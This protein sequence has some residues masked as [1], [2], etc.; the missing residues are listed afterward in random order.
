MNREISAPASAAFGVALAGLAAGP[1]EAAVVSLT[2]TPATLPYGAGTF[3]VADAYV[4][5]LAGTSAI[6]TF[7]A[8]NN[9]YGKSF[10]GTSGFFPAVSGSL[11]WIGTAPATITTGLTF[12]TGVFAT[13][14]S[15]GTRTVAFRTDANQLG[16]LRVSFG[17]QGGT[18][19][20]LAAAYETTPGA[21]IGAGEGPTAIPLPATLPLAGLGL[22]ALG[23]A[24]LRRKRTA[25]AAG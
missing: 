23:A 25:V 18:V 7:A 1:A 22:L 4:Q 15:T 2:A 14:S 12:A 11:G 20:Y 13:A 21:P 6:G 5:L 9:A 8:F 16:W 19:A 10:G 17:G 3:G 24:G